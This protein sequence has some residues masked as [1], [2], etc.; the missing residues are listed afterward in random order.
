MSTVTTPAS[1]PIFSEKIGGE[2]YFQKKSGSERG[3]KRSGG[4]PACRRAASIPVSPVLIPRS[5][6]CM[7]RL[8]L[9]GPSFCGDRHSCPESG[10][11]TTPFHHIYGGRAITII[12]VHILS[13]AERDQAREERPSRPAAHP[14]RRRSPRS[15]EIS[16][17]GVTLELLKLA[18]S[19]YRYQFPAG[20][21][22]LPIRAQPYQSGH[23]PDGN[24]RR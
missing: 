16:G 13:A 23:S 21:L 4:V 9:R 19:G 11:E 3:A 2:Y 20:Y 17:M 15:S 18:R 7:I 8:E 6:A 22:R 12:S 1:P 5:T 14:P 24:L 10:V